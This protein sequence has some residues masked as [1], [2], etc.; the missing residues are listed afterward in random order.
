[1]GPNGLRVH[2]SGPEVIL[3]ND[4]SELRWGAEQRLEFIEFCLFWE[5]HVNRSYLM[6]QFGVSVNQ[7]S[8]DPNRYTEEAA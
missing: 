8:T 3:E 6:D 1:M 4:R 7:A 5:G 2:R